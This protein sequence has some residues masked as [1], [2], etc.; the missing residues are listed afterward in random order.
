MVFSEVAYSSIQLYT[1]PVFLNQRWPGHDIH[2]QGV[3][4]AS[5]FQTAEKARGQFRQHFQE[6]TAKQTPLTT[7]K[8]QLALEL[9]QLALVLI[10]IIC[11][12]PVGFGRIM[13]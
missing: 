12:R 4:S 1:P 3:V 13:P 6:S 5:P 8:C 11:N 9:P 10:Y 2:L 7:K